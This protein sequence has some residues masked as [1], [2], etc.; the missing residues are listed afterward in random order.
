MK[1]KNGLEEDKI[2]LESGFLISSTQ[3][4]DKRNDI[5]LGTR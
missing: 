1:P 3:S 4:K 5:V 2:G